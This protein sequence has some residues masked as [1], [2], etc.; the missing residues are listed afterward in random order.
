MESFLDRGRDTPSLQE[1]R[2]LQ[3][4][5]DAGRVDDDR[6]AA[7]VD[8]GPF[9]G[10]DQDADAGAVHEVHRAQIN[11]QVTRRVPRQ[12]FD[13]YLPEA[14]GAGQIHLA[15]DLDDSGVLPMLN[16]AAELVHRQREVRLSRR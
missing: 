12:D 14:R 16:P 4:P 10:A 6:E 3:Y 8:C 15:A 9:A 13:Q 5:A 2:Y 11:D 1:T 7:T